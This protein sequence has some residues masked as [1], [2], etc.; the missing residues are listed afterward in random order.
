MHVFDGQTDKDFHSKTAC[1]RSRMV[2]YR[3][4]KN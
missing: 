4:T 2:K 1:I 3:S